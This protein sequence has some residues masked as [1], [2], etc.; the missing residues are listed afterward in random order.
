MGDTS[1][2][3]SQGL[4]CLFSAPPQ[5][6]AA[7]SLLSAEQEQTHEE[8]FLG[9]WVSEVG[10]NLSSPGLWALPGQSLCPQD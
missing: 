7:P 5:E 4:S 2:G 9:E 3:R 10:K 1:K 8:G 6:T